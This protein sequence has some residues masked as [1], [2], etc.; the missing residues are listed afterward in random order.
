MVVLGGGNFLMSE[1]PLYAG[2]QCYACSVWAGR[3]EWCACRR[4]W[5]RR[6]EPRESGFPARES[7]GYLIPGRRASRRALI[8][9][10]RHRETL[11]VSKASLGRTGI[12]ST[13]GLISPSGRDCVKSL[14]SSYTGL[15][16]YEAISTSG[17]SY[18]QKLRSVVK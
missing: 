15:H 12:R 5:T 4:K 2:L 14:R 9:R 16:P 7:Q 6:L 10:S 11:C 17:F 8:G 18:L 1:V 13:C 3:K